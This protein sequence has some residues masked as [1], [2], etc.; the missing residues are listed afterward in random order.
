MASQVSVPRKAV[1]A[2]LWSFAFLSYLLRTNIAV[3]QQ[4]M[5]REFGFNDVQIGAIFSAFLIGYTLFQIPGGVLG[6]KFGAR[7]VLGAVALW[8]VVTTAL[9]GLLPGRV[10]SG[11]TIAL[12]VVVALRFIHGI[13]E[14]ATYPVAMRAVSDWFPARQHA[15]INALIFTGST[16]GSAFA[17]PL[18][19]HLM[20]T[21]GWRATFYLAAIL[22]LG[23]AFLWLWQTKGL[24]CVESTRAKDEK[25][26]WW[27]IFKTR[28]V[29]FLCLSYFLYCYSISIFVYWLFKYLVDVR[30]LSIVN[31]GWATSLPWI[32]ATVAV[33]VFGYVS[34]RLSD[35]I[36]VLQGR[37]AVA[38]GCLLAASVLL[39]VGARPSN[40]G[41]AIGAIALSVGLL[42]ST[43]SS[44]F[45][46]A[47]EVARQDAGAASGLMNLAGNMGSVAATSA[48]PLL[49]LRYGWFTALLSGSALAI[50]AAV[51]WFG[52]DAP[53]S[54]G[55]AS[56]ARIEGGLGAGVTGRAVE[57]R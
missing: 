43:E 44:Y 55:A 5:A 39:Y 25:G 4:Y 40:I 19:A 9:T 57:E 41:V 24:P 30:H 33:P 38:V 22:P 16:S 52:L 26:T 27:R 7:L 36:G 50:L 51:A 8:W 13:G 21:L 12:M 32:T 2:L 48:V 35:R 37:R 29:F 6:D 34:T 46:T 54:S 53:G 1:V 18:V 20:T 42:F 14:A 47:I 17:P 45:S 56:A 31:S 10:G 28:N 23:V 11:A 15:F 49:V 3:A